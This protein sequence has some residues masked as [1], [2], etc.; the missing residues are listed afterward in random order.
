[1][2]RRLSFFARK[3]DQEGKKGNSKTSTAQAPQALGKNSD[4]PGASHPETILTLDPT[5]QDPVNDAPVRR[6]RNGQRPPSAAP[7]DEAQTVLASS[8][9][10]QKAVLN[11]WEAARSRLVQENFDITS[12][13]D[14]II[15]SRTSSTATSNVSSHNPD[16]LKDF[17]DRQL[18]SI[19]QKQWRLHLGK[20]SLGVRDTLER[21]IGILT[22]IQRIYHPS[23]YSGSS[24]CW[25]ARGSNVSDCYG[26]L[27]DTRD[28]LNTIS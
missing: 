25:P 8:A 21:V 20:V 17:I 22:A 11:L 24:P 26:M 2:P 28:D 6:D 3:G 7:E 16:I 1:M 5:Q 14:E 10:S 4:G 13:F 18:N 15:A 23:R 9:L 19:K 12:K 27:S